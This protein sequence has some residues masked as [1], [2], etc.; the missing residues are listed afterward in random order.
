[1]KYKNLFLTTTLP[2]LTLFAISQPVFAA[3]CGGADTAIIS[4]DQDN[5]STDVEDNGVW[6][7]LI[8]VINILAAGVGIVAVGGI[9]YGA[10][11]YASAEDKSDQ[12]AK[13]KQIITNVVIGLIMF[14][15]MVSLLNYLIPGGVFNV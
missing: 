10:M 3:E 9:V 11:M 14:A 6:G 15:L 13:A 8:L 4:C 5:S 7:L 12:V 1:M 2:L